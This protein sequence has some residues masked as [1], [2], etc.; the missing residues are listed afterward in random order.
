MDTAIRTAI[1]DILSRQTD[2]TI[3]TVRSDGYP[4]ATTVSFVNDDLLLYFGCGPLSQKAKNIARNDKVSV[5]VTP[6]YTDWNSI[7]GLSLGGRACLITDA[8]EITRLSGLFFNRFP[9]VVQYA[10]QDRS[11]LAL[12]MI[13]PEVISILD[14]RKG[15]GHADQI[16][17]RR[18][19]TSS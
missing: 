3:A 12:I 9:F 15:F 4:Q 16:D 10:P 14:Y 6:P 18:D 11:E 2:M 8:G 7:R 1:L 19:A 13:R 5:T 17:L